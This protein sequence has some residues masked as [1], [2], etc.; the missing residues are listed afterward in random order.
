MIV[1][2]V[3]EISKF[4][5]LLSALPEVSGCFYLTPLILV[6]ERVAGRIILLSEVA[7]VVE[8]ADT[9]GAGLEE[10]AVVLAGVAAVIAGPELQVQI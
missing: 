7:R 10:T 5:C 3:L 2:I 8:G 4:T 9:K 1:I 6:T